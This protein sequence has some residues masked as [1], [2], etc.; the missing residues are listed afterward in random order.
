MI[1]PRLY[2]AYR[3]ALLPDCVLW[4]DDPVRWLA[5]SDAWTGDYQHP[6]VVAIRKRLGK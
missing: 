2:H 6:A 1:A 5:L 3:A 4:S